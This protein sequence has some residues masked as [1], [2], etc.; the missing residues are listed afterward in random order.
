M[1]KFGKTQVSDQA[2]Q[3]CEPPEREPSK[4][5]PLKR[6]PLKRKPDELHWIEIE[7][8]Y[9]EG[10]KPVADEEFLIKLPDGAEVRGRLNKDGTA[11]VDSIPIPGNCEITF[12]NLDKELWKPA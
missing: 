11:R 2:V 1:A 7:L 4:R 3:P 10:G 5:K 9:E 8:V 12:P 6:K